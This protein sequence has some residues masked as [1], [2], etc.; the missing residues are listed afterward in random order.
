MDESKAA[1]V[2][3]DGRPEPWGRCEW[4]ACAIELVPDDRTASAG[5]LS[6]QLVPAASGGGKFDE[7]KLPEPLYNPGP[8]V[9]LPAGDV[10]V[11]TV[12]LVGLVC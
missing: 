10:L 2:Q 12:V 9:A 7:R 11:V 1:G 6:P 8:N 5:Q 3:R 4:K